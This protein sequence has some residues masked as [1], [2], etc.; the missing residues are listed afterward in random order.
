M[1]EIIFDPSIETVQNQVAPLTAEHRL[2]VICGLFSATGELALVQ[3]VHSA[4]EEIPILGLKMPQGGVKKGEDLAAAYLREIYEEV[5]V[6]PEDIREI[7]GVP[8]QPPLTGGR[9]RG[10][11]GSKVFG[12]LYGTTSGRPNL[13]PKPGE[14]A[15]AG[16]FTILGAYARFGTQAASPE[17]LT[18]GRRSQ[19]VLDAM[20]VDISAHQ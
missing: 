16:W 14:I 3:T 11:K 2:T 1:P 4:A 7:Y 17:H 8:L 13:R 12:I 19:R 5:G 10:G 18:R 15:A 9:A 6:Q 20:L